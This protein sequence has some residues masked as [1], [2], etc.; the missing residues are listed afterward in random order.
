MIYEFIRALDNGEEAIGRTDH[1]FH[2][3]WTGKLFKQ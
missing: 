3:M 1:T 2:G